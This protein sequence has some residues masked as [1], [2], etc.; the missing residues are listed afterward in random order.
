[1]A[2]GVWNRVVVRALLVGLLGGALVGAARD[3]HAAP[4]A[5]AVDLNADTRSLVAQLTAER[6]LTLANARGQAD[7]AQDELYKQ[8]NDKDRALRAAQARAAHNAAALAQARKDRAELARQREDLVAA[9]ARRDQTLAA[10]VRAYREGITQLASSPDPQKQKAL[11]RFADGEQVEALADLD[12]IADGKRTAHQ[13]A[14]DLAD[15]AERRPTAWLA[16]QAHDQGHE[17]LDRVV[18]RFE[19]LTQLDPTMGSDW[20][21][22]G[23]LYREQG[24]LADARRAAEA[25]YKNLPDGDE[26]NRGVVLEDLGEFAFEAGD[27]RGAKALFEEGLVI[28][29]KLV[30][31]NPTSVEAQRDLSV[32]LERLGHVAFHTGDLAGAKA[33]F[34]EE[35]VIRRK[36]AQENPTS[37][38]AQSDLSVSFEKLGDVA[39]KAGDLAGAKVRFEDAMVIRRKL[40]QAN[41]TSAQI[42]LGIGFSLHKLGEVAADTG[43]L[44]GAKARFAEELAIHRKLAQADPTSAEVQRD[45]SVSLNSLGVVAANTGD[46]AG[47]KARF[48]EVV[49]IRRKLAQTNPTSAEAQRD[50]SGSLE[51]LG[52]VAVSAGDLAGAK[53]RFAEELAIRRKLAQADPASAEAQLDLSK[54][55]FQLGLVTRDRSRLSEALQIVRGLE[56]TGRLAPA[57]RRLLKVISQAID[58][59]RSRR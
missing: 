43:D 36:L 46:L 49:G 24:R 23:R 16:L 58:S 8:L 42:Q 48:E 26:R 5:E 57:D 27:R 44:A 18:R 20:L 31:E 21:A 47:A 50:L 14:V 33:S 11:Q 55:L 6:A 17:T 28:A 35:L 13:N 1:M 37:A 4:S 29:R 22:L 32:S 7:A 54:A 41:P 25:A 59:L 19:Q 45:L 40:A 34:E 53:A 51:K 39:V 9:L 15:A 10:E 3:A 12:M 56:Q 30:Q 52:E 38:E 2:G